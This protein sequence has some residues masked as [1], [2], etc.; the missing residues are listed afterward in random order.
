MKNREADALRWLSQ[1]E[2]DLEFARLALRERFYA[3]ACF[4]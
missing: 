2:N 1:S 3:Q 4:M